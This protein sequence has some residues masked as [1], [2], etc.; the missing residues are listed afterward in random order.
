M[1]HH[2]Q[3]TRTLIAAAALTVAAATGLATAALAAPGGSRPAPDSLRA[4][5]ARVGL[6]VGTAVIPND[7]TNPEYSS[8]VAGQFSVL[9]PGNAMKW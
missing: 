4:L 7:L 6:R 5:G 8:I 9:T 1:R 3:L 2:R